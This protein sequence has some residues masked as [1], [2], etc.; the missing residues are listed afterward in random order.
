M[1]V[2]LN[3][4]FS[5][6]LIASLSSCLTLS[7]EDQEKQIDANIEFQEWILLHG[8]SKQP[9]LKYTI[10]KITGNP[11]VSLESKLT[12][13]DANGDVIGINKLN[14]VINE[15]IK[16]DS[17]VLSQDDTSKKISTVKISDVFL[18]GQDYS[19]VE[20]TFP[21]IEQN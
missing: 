19:S 16:I 12:Y 8:S 3:I 7:A 2:F 10:K 13:R 20:K 1:K 6:F 21:V 11:S 18:D 4:L 9:V 17:I 5:F 15:N 14:V